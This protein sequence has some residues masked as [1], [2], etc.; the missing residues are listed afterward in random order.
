MY[1]KIP[2]PIVEWDKKGG[3][4][5]LMFLSLV[6]LAC[7]AVSLGVYHLAKLLSLSSALF[8][9]FMLLSLVLVCGFLHI[10]G[11][12][13]TMDALLS[14]RGREEKIRILKDSTVGA[15]SVVA[16]VILMIFNYSSFFTLSTLSLTPYI[17]L[18]I[19]FVSRAISVIIMF[20]FKSLSDKGIMAYFKQGNKPI[21]IIIILF[22][23]LI[24]FVLSYI[25]GF[26]YLLSIIFEVVTMFA[27][28]LLGLKA[29]GGI[30]G[31]I[32][33]ASVVLGEAV[34]YLSLGILLGL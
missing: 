2:V 29:L 15:F 34:A 7:G 16:L 8:S 20:E 13:D 3:A 33:G 30:N 9:A 12:M 32:L 23:V 24:A 28:S 18:I 1:S 6:G 26:N 17:L 14:S 25:M 5:S 4:N 31:D 27:I 19:P 21:H 11:F 10:D 22:Q